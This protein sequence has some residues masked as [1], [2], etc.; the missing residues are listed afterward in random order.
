[1]GKTQTWI[2]LTTHNIIMEKIVGLTGA[3]IVMTGQMIYILNCLRGKITP[4]V[5]TWF[6]WSVL[7]CIT[8]ISQIIH[9]GWQWSMTA[10][11]FSTVGC[12]AIT[13][14]AW[15]SNNYSFQRSDL[16]FV[17]AGFACVVVYVLSANP[18]ATTIFAIISD[19]LL[20]AP[21]IIKAW[22]APAQERS[23]SWV[24]SMTSAL[25]ALFICIGHETIYFLF[26]VY[27]LLYNGT[28]VQMTWIR[29]Q[30]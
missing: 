17:A 23:V 1:M 14:V 3:L 20:G 22:R 28:M 10:I 29:R 4:S 7:M 26:P 11:A 12:L 13:I 30:H 18:W 6:G 5:L 9:G 21:T 16:K 19:A 8:L 2:T 15:L 25:L 24:L 27:L